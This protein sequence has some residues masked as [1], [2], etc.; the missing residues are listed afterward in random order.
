MSKEDAVTE[1]QRMLEEMTEEEAVEAY[2]FFK[3]NYDV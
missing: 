1:I 3:E 2:W